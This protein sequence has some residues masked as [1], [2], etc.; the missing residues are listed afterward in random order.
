MLLLPVVNTSPKQEQRHGA[1]TGLPESQEFI[2][3]ALS[4]PNIN[5]IR[6]K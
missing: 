1:P 6:K 5:A 3:L 4:E 2:I